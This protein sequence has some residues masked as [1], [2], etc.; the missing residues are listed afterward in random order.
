M[1]IKK[2]E[3]VSRMNWSKV[4]ATFPSAGSRDWA[5]EGRKKEPMTLTKEKVV[6]TEMVRM[7][8]SHRARWTFSMARMRELE[9]SGNAL[10]RSLPTEMVVIV[11]YGNNRTTSS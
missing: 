6:E 11:A 3:L 2:D 10:R 9:C 5:A 8:R 7:S 1:L 4:L